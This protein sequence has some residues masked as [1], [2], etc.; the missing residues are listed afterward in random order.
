MLLLK[1]STFKE[2]NLLFL[3]REKQSIKIIAIFY[4]FRKITDS[5]IK[6]F[7]QKSLL[8]YI[9]LYL[10]TSNPL[11]QRIKLYFN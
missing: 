1:K 4:Q 2:N 3:E 11:N 8:K 9:M 7:L 6:I 10:Q 5:T